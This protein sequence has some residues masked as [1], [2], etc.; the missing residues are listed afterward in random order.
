MQLFINLVWQLVQVV[1]PL[2]II[3]TLDLAG[4]LSD[5]HGDFQQRK[6]KE[7]SLGSDFFSFP[8]TLIKYFL[9]KEKGFTVK[10]IL[11]LVS[12]YAEQ[13]I[14]SYSRIL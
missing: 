14:F 7:S 6:S 11:L 5:Q 12:T 2:K 9:R 3:I 1:S 13:E 4:S 10:K 8:V